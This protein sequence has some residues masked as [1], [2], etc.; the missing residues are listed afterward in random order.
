MMSLQPGKKL[1]RPGLSGSLAACLLLVLSA[2]FGLARPCH[3]QDAFAELE[4]KAAFIVRSASFVTWPSS[5]VPNEKSPIRIAVLGSDQMAAEL[6]KFIQAQK[7]PTRSFT[8]RRISNAFEARDA[9]IL[10]IGE[11][12]SRRTAQIIDI[13]KDLPVLTVGES[14][15]FFEHGGMLHLFVEKE[16]LAIEVNLP[17]AEQAKLNLSSKLVTLAK[18][19]IRGGNQK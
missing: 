11:S 2:L 10:F 1:I 14:K 9:E 5:R 13:V 18:R 15:E 8:V 19:V 4:V 16:R 17:A 6:E 12:E 7:N 3:A